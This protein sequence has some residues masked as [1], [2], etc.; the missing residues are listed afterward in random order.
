[1]AGDV[2]L[3][4]VET[5]ARRRH[6]LAVHAVLSGLAL[7]ARPTTHLR[8]GT[9][10]GGAGPRFYGKCCES[11]SDA[12]MPANKPGSRSRPG[13]PSRISSAHQLL[14]AR[15]APPKQIPKPFRAILAAFLREPIELRRGASANLA[16]PAPVRRIDP[17]NGDSP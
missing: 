1:M 9:G 7:R 16:L 17:I 15:A 12:A 11:F 4:V 14:G 6:V 8:A 10:A 5:D 13:R 2:D 3:Y